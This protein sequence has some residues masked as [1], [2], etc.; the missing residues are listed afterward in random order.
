[1]D[2]TVP[3]SARWA[4]HMTTRSIDDRLERAAGNGVV[5]DPLFDANTQDPDARLQAEVHRVAQPRDTL[6][7]RAPRGDPATTGF[8]DIFPPHVFI[9]G[10]GQPLR[11]A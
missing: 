11:I 10:W 1:M 5:S 9:P 4:G 8:W 3:I 7:P 2:A 6:R